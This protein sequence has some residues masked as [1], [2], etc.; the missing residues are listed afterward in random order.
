MAENFDFAGQLVGAGNRNRS[1]QEDQEFDFASGLVNS[2]KATSGSKA[3]DGNFPD[4]RSPIKAYSD[5]SRGASVIDALIGGIPTDTNAAKSY[6]AKKRGIPE[7]RYAILDGNVVY[8][9]DDGKWYKEV[10]GVLPNIAYR[11]PDVVEMAPGAVTG[12]AMAPVAMSGPAGL[13]GAGA[14]VASVD[15]GMNYGRQKLAGAIANQQYDPFETAL[16][17]GLSFLAES[18]PMVKKLA[19]ERRLASDFAQRNLV[20]EAALRAK[21]GQYGIPLTAAEIT[22]LPSLM[23]QQKVLGNIT[24]SSNK[25]E[26]FYTSRE[27]ASRNA[28]NDY[29]NAISSVDDVADAGKIGQDALN[30][31]KA[32]LEQQRDNAV[33]PIYEQAFKNASP[34]DTSGVLNR[35][36]SFMANAPDGSTM[37]RYLSRMRQMVQGGDLAMLHNAKMELDAM[38][39]EDAF[40]SLDKTMQ[41]QLMGVKDELVSAMGKSNPQYT[42][43]NAEFARL[44][45]PVNEFNDRI[46]GT[47]L[48]RIQPDNLKNF[49]SRIFENPSAKTVDYAK[50][51]IIA[52][53]GQDAWNAVTRA[54][55]ENAWT[56]SKKPSKGAMGQKIDAGRT[57]NNI[58]FGDEKQDAAI[59]VALEPQQYQ[60]LRD[61]AN[62]LEAAGR[63]KKL[64]S[65]TAFNQLVT[66]E[67][68]K[69]PPMTGIG[70]GAARVGGAILQPQNYGKMVSDWAVKRDATRNADK[71]ADII[72]QPDAIEQLKQLRK[73]Q[74]TE[75]KFWAGLTRVLGSSGVLHVYRS[76][77]DTAIADQT[78]N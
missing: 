68:Q 66:E 75:A 4:L 37:G 31:Q 61:L 58:L 49:A 53:G 24:P 60:A 23:T 26:K 19:K 48:T 6:F 40:G 72:M 57:W 41:R 43:A 18:A 32:A 39:K 51:Q 59:R 55:L 67:L 5:P 21:A 56:A 62:V 7:D 74:P 69:N 44:S 63:V 27:E 13:L 76:P 28:V 64:G 12:V 34:V 29:L 9:A 17:G 77:T 30:A 20:T 35:V 65:D 15:A 78:G 22:S 3:G 52:G 71:L 8:R 2:N 10:S 1:V 16:S 45:Q 47:S 11:V 73:M 14:T 33:R 46:T 54:H 50:K 70:T 36:D 25:M 38:F 42:A